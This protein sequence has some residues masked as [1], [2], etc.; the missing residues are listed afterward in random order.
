MTE[1]CV[2]CKYQVWLNRNGARVRSCDRYGECKY[3]AKHNCYSCEGYRDAVIGIDTPIGKE[4][5][6]YDAWVRGLNRNPEDGC[7]YWEQKEDT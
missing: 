5:F 4:C 7:E 3:E 2:S 6:C 1:R